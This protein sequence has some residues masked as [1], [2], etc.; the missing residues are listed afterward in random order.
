[1]EE[2]LGVGESARWW[3]STTVC[4]ECVEKSTARKNRTSIS[5]LSNGLEQFDGGRANPEPARSANTK[6][7][8]RINPQQTH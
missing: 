8:S 2:K 4:V 3:K 6:K 1:M 5:V 7:V